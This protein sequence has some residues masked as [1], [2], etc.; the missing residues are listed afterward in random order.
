MSFFLDGSSPQAKRRRLTNVDVNMVQP[1]NPPIDT[2]TQALGLRST[3]N[4]REACT[5]TGAAKLI[6]HNFVDDCL[7]RVISD[8][9]S[10]IFKKSITFP[11]TECVRV[12]D[13]MTAISL[14]FQDEWAHISSSSNQA[15][16]ACHM[17][18]LY[19]VSNS[20]SSKFETF[21]ENN[22]TY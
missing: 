15:D 1:N 9:G 2:L 11:A 4:L 22:L 12:N 20:N 5:A 8:G 13:V 17:I 7:I 14:L 18:T 10:I 19:R 16:P 3:N 6:I 21:C